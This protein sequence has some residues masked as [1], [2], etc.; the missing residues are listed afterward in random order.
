M[1]LPFLC[2]IL[3]G[4]EGEV[5]ILNFSSEFLRPKIF[6]TAFSCYVNET[7]PGWSFRGW[8]LLLSG[9]L[10][11]DGNDPD[12][13]AVWLGCCDVWRRIASPVLDFL[14][15][16]TKKRGGPGDWAILVKKRWKNNGQDRSF[17]KV[18]AN[19][20]KDD[21][22]M[23]ASCS[24]GFLGSFF[25]LTKKKRIWETRGSAEIWSGTALAGERRTC[26]SRWSNGNLRSLDPLEV[27]NST[28]PPRI[29]TISRDSW[30]NTKIS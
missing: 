25:P 6:V 26:R 21:G 13:G 24:L 16:V 3:E 7:K 23:V 15:T 19:C 11:G 1:A 2:F 28:A 29:R 14:I 12:E 5:W 20:K 17:G 30:E 27:G 4:C 8:Y 18:R 9:Q 10:V 22:K